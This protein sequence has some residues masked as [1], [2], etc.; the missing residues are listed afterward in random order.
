MTDENLRKDV[1]SQYQPDENNDDSPI[2]FR[3]ANAEDEGNERDNHL[4]I[5]SIG[6][7]FHK[8]KKEEEVKEVSEEE[9]KND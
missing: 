3:N 2:T 7:E 5:E 9:E 6:S 8:I 1:N 4:R